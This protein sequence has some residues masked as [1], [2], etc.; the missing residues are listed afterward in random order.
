MPISWHFTVYIAVDGPLGAYLQYLPAAVPDLK[1]V[2]W[3]A[4]G[5]HHITLHFLG[6]HEGEISENWISEIISRLMRVKFPPFEVR[7]KQLNRFKGSKGIHATLDRE[8]GMD[9]LHRSTLN[10]LNDISGFA[11][12]TPYVPHITLW[13]LPHIGINVSDTIWEKVEG[14]LK[15]A[16][17]LVVESICLHGYR[18]DEK[19]HK[20]TRWIIQHMRSPSGTYTT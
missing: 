18:T 5:D 6:R 10:V 3:T 19:T 15:A 9:H 2:N 13:Q 11:S 17:P 1:D 20:G 16:P 12:R 4:H 8:N 14:F 7:L